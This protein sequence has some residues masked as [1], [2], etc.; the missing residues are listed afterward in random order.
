MAATTPIWEV[1]ALRYAHLDRLLREVS[2]FAD[3]HDGALAP[4]DYFVWVAIPMDQDGRRM[5][6]A[7]PVVIDSG[8]NAA[9]AKKR[10][11]NFLRCP[12]ET[13]RAIG[14]DAGAVEDLIV[15]HLH[16]DHIGN[17]DLF[18]KARFH[19]QDKEMQFATGREM[20]HPLFRYAFEVEDI[21]GMV[22][23]NHKGRV[24]WHDGDGEVAPGLSVHLIGGHTMGIQCVRIMTRNGP[25]VLASDTSHYYWGFEKADLFH[26]V[27]DV[28]KMLSGYETLDRLA[29]GRREMIVPGHDAEVMK[30]YPVSA[31]GLEGFAVRLD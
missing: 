10:G 30:R 25:L 13:M 22:R 27:F 7:R 15:T 12:T 3:P 17:W 20:R 14:V 28:S 11:R 1:H 29:E 26:I 19:L 18:P 6:G 9:T 8:F 16:Y 4:M 2:I 31:P 24:A 5:V 21:V 23:E